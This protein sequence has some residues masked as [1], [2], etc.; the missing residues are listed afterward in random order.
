M[1]AE[2][3]STGRSYTLHVDVPRNIWDT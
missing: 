3:L 2:I 1:P